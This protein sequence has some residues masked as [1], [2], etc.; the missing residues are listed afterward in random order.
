MIFRAI[1]GLSARATGRNM[2]L[3]PE[4]ADSRGVAYPSLTGMSDR[5]GYVSEL[6]VELGEDIEA[7]DVSPLIS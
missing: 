2:Y 5:G 4:K 1:S 6:T 7:L 3:F